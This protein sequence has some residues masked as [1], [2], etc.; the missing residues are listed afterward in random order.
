MR[1]SEDR[2]AELIADITVRLARHTEFSAGTTPAETTALA[3]ADA[4]RTL[5]FIAASRGDYEPM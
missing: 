2:T 3:R 1:T 4:E 5:A